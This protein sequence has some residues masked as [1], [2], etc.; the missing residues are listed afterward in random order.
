[1]TGVIA[2]ASRAPMEG[3]GVKGLVSDQSA[4]IDGFD[5]RLSASQIVILARAE[6]SPVRDGPGRRR[7]HEFGGSVRRGIYLWPRTVFGCGVMLVSAH[8]GGVNHHVIVVVIARQELKTRSKTPLWAHRLKR[9]IDDLPVAKALGLMGSLGRLE[10][11]RGRLRR[12]GDLSAAVPPDMAFTARQNEFDP[13]SHWSSRRAYR[14]IGQPLPGLT[15]H[16]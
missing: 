3:V 2:R 7:A 10:T 4:G 6:A 13:I 1:M 15:T 8:D 11:G 14:R 16:E 12:T 5:E 9:W